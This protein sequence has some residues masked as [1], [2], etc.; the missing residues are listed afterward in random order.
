MSKKEVSLNG[1]ERERGRVSDVTPLLNASDRRPPVAPPLIFVADFEAA[2]KVLIKR[3]P[4]GS[5]N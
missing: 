3:H 4:R 2:D 1:P 5:R